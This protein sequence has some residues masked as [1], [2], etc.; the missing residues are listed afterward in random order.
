MTPAELPPRTLAAQHRE[1]LDEPH[2]E[3][4]VGRRAGATAKARL[5]KMAEIPS[6]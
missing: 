3:R 4:A 6:V 2:E 5:A 1:T